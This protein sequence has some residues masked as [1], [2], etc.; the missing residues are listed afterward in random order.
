[1]LPAVERFLREGSESLRQHSFVRALA[2]ADSA[3]A[4]QPDLA[5]IPFLRGRV[6]SEMARLQE[7][8]SLYR[9]V[10]ETRPDYPGVWHNLGNTAFRLKRY[11][12]AIEYYELEIEVHGGAQP[13]RGLGRAYVEL[14]KTDSARFAFERAIETDSTLAQAHFSLALLLDDLGDLEGAAASARRASVAEPEN[15]EYR[16]YMASYLLRLGRSVEAIESLGQVIADWPWHQGAHYNMAQALMR[17]GR[18][19]DARVFQ[20]RAEQ[21]R[22]LQAQIS[23]HENTVR[24]QPTNAYAHAGLGTLLRRAGRYND[25]MHAYRVALFLEPSNLDYRNNVAVLHLLRGDTTAAVASFEDIVATDTSNVNAWINLGSLYA[26]S[27]E[28]EAARAAWST[29][30]RLEP[31]NELARESLKKR[32]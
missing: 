16:Y 10:L 21:L 22:E 25:A 17:L 30:L 31:D 19:S 24:V 8:D 6:Y 1:M 15:P 28:L 29:A 23:H 4:L 5:D 32:D 13:W 11:T 18:T 12:E 2:F 3:E 20:D 26:M 14:G 27:G 7:A 9:I